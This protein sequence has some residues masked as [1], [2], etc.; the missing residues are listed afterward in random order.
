MCPKISR[1]G[2]GHAEKS[3]SYSLKLKATDST[4]IWLMELGAKSKSVY[5]VGIPVHALWRSWC[6]VSSVDYD[7][8]GGLVARIWHE[9]RYRPCPTACAI[10]KLWSGK[11]ILL[12]NK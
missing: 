11:L 7:V 4:G 2:K 1:E 3:F 5:T 12:L 10:A 6:T 8:D 9:Q